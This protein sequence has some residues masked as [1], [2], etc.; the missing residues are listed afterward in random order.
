MQS[1]FAQVQ[2]I[3]QTW[4]T[5]AKE[6]MAFKEHNCIVAATNAKDLVGFLRSSEPLLRVWM[7]DYLSKNRETIFIKS[8]SS[9]MLHW[10]KDL[11]KERWP[12]IQLHSD[13]ANQWNS[14]F[15]S[16]PGL[17]FELAER[18]VKEAKNRICQDHF[19]IKEHLH[20]IDDLTILGI[21]D[22][23]P[24]D[25]CP[26]QGCDICE[27]QY[28]AWKEELFRRISQSQHPLLNSE[29][30]Y[31]W[32]IRECFE[33][34]PL[35]DDWLP[36]HNWLRSKFYSCRFE[37]GQWYYDFN[38]F[39]DKMIKTLSVPLG[40]HGES[41][42]SACSSF[43]SDLC[44]WA[45]MDPRDHKKDFTKEYEVFDFL[46]NSLDIIHESYDLV[47]ER[48]QEITDMF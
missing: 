33:E 14:V 17:C 26:W 41:P 35:A 27:N 11:I 6:L 4:N 13:L 48:A 38:Q 18:V 7:N 10:T 39:R 46:W 9:L 32:R 42:S 1:S 22:G 24:C 19:E 40:S 45:L 3:L 21:H 29:A 12:S 23:L 31:S 5:K 20:Q 25:V 34:K 15:G 37:H 44:N 2:E 28:E 43:L 16:K 47:L 30:R 36:P 8:Y